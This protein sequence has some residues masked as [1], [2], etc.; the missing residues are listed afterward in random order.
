MKHASILLTGVA[1]VGLLGCGGGTDGRVETVPVQ[2]QLLVD[3][4]PQGSVSLVF[5]P[6]GGDGTDL[7][8]VAGAT[9][10]ADGTFSVGTYELAD[11]AAPGQYEVSISTT[12][13]MTDPAAMGQG[14]A[15]SVSAAPTTVE[16]PA[17]GATDLQVELK[18]TGPAPSRGGAGRPLGT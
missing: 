4:K 13:S 5:K 7:R 14:G 16:V 2:G 12:S 11:G 8:P 18:S 15:A 9:T 17:D 6:V 3:G 10:A 1:V